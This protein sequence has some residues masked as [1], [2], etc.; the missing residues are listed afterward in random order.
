MWEIFHVTQF[1]NHLKYVLQTQY[2]NKI[3][4]IEKD[5]YAKKVTED[6][7]QWSQKRGPLFTHIYLDEAIKE[8]Y[9]N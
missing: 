4:T 6:V 5:Q 2:R 3:I 8:W 7:Y 1:P 9:K